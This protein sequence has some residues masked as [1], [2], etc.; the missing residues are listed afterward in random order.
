MVLFWLHRIALIVHIASLYA[1]HRVNLRTLSKILCLFQTHGGPLTGTSHVNGDVRFIQIQHTSI[2]LI[3]SLG[4]FQKPLDHF[5]GP[6]AEEEL[7][8]NAKAMGAVIGK[9]GKGH[10]MSQGSLMQSRK[11]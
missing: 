7:E 4:F 1:I 5:F 8:L 2:E 3:L 9:G 10:R 11:T 6:Q